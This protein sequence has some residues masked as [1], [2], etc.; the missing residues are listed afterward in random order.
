MK[1][2]LEAVETMLTDTQTRL[3]N[4]ETQIVE[5]KTQG[6]SNLWTDLI[7]YLSSEVLTEMFPQ[8]VFVFFT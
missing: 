1:D 7:N 3:L 5:L 8:N 6:G 2:K 4:S